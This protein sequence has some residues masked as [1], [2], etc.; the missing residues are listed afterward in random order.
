MNSEKP[1]PTEIIEIPK[2][3]LKQFNEIKPRENIPT[4]YDYERTS[5]YIHDI[6]IHLSLLQ[7]YLNDKPSQGFERLG[8]RINPTLHLIKDSFS[9]INITEKLSTDFYV[10]VIKK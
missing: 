8:I 7:N 4:D 2:A 3:L 5:L 1:K 9:T 10:Q 6:P